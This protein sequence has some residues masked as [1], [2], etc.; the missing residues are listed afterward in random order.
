MT[1]AS[2]HCDVFKGDVN[3]LLTPVCW[4]TNIKYCDFSVEVKWK[5]C[6]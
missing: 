6:D 1:K 2:T 3:V 5:L 4:L